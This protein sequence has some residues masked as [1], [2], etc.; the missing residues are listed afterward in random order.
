MLTESDPGGLGNIVLSSFN[1][2]TDLV[3]LNVDNSSFIGQNTWGSGVSAGG[4]TYDGAQ[5]HLLTESDPGGLG[6]IVLSSFNS[7]ADLVN[8]N[9]DNSSFI[10]QNTWGSGVSAGGLASSSMQSFQVPEPTTLS[11]LG[12]AFAGLGWSWRKNSRIK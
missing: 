8:L 7:L 12:L 5:Y 3:N 1:S 10:G 2:L 9:V 11:L 4:L 6:N